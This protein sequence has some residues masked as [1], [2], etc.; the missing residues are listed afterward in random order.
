M[1]EIGDCRCFLQHGM[2][3]SGFTRVL[4][5]AVQLPGADENE[6]DQRQDTQNRQTQRDRSIEKKR[7]HVRSF[8][9]AAISYDYVF[10]RQNF[11]WVKFDSICNKWAK[12]NR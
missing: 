7:R 8:S 12:K 1:N 3:E 10:A 11:P 9:A 2:N 4:I 6:C 5:F